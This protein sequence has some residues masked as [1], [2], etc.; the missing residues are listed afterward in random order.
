MVDVGD[1]DEVGLVVVVVGE[2]VVGDIVVGE[3]YV[4]GGADSKF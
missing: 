4:V 1:D 3:V 2:T